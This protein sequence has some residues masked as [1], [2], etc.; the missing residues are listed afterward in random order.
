[1]LTAAHKESIQQAYRRW[2][3]SKALRARY[4]QRLMIAEVARTV[5]AAGADEPPLTAIEAGTGTGKTVAYCMAAIPLAQAL[6]KTLVIATGTVALQ[7]QIVFKDLPDLQTH[8]GLTFSYTMAKGRGRYLCLAKVDAALSAQQNEPLF[9]LY[10]DEEQ[11]VSDQAQQQLWRDMLDRLAEGRWDGDRDLWPEQIDDAAWRR[12]TTDHAQCTG[13]RCPHVRQCA[14][15]KARDQIGK[16]DVVV[17]NHDLVLADLALG[18]GAILPDPA[19]TIYIFDEGHHL[20]DKAR[21]HFAHSLRLRGTDR[22]LEQSLKLLATAAGEL[23]PAAGIDRQLELMPGIIHELRKGIAALRPGLEQLL[24]S[25]LADGSRD[26]AYRFEH[27]LVPAA[28]REL[29]EQLRVGFSDF[30]DRLGRV[31]HALEQALDG[32]DAGLSRELAERWYPAISVLRV[33]AEAAQELW[34]FF[35]RDASDE[36]PPR[37]RWL[38]P[39]TAAS[40]AIDVELH[41]SPIMAGGTLANNLWS[42]C[43]AAVITS[44]TLTALGRFDRFAIR[45]GLP[46]RA[47]RVVVPSPFD[48]ASAAVLSVP[49]MT[50]DPGDPEGHTAML[51]AMLPELLDPAEGSLVLFSAR[52]QM[53]SVQEALPPEWQER[54]LMQGQLGKQ[55]LLNR[56]RDRIDSGEGSV[57]FGLASFAE[58]LDLPGSYC[59]HVVIAKIPFAVPDEPVEA[60]LAEWISSRGGN[61]FMEIAVPDAAL[62]LVQASGRLLR[63]E[64]DRGRIT[65]LDRRIVSRRYGRAILDS[66]P[67]FR[68]EIAASSGRAS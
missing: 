2:L 35:A 39:I 47:S 51:V 3:E 12:V 17:T 34:Y 63:S 31:A 19:D 7:E 36:Q 58:G 38:A 25:A 28:I 42:R 8:S 13:R 21:D 64:Q 66:L 68:R 45:A 60:A 10:P 57:L 41:C 23:G 32:G 52:R 18:G 16:V 15:F 59:A 37:A 67:P 40:G 27:G 9:A 65:L 26:A 49:A 46:E 56:H 43:A 33:R 44:A 30:A 50:A 48:H 11:S 55:E 6:D 54:I 29:A 1:M 61:P 24:D 5:A 62:K 4:G 53:E 20:P 22:H 14:F